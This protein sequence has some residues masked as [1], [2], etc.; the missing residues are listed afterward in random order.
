MTRPVPQPSE[1]IAVHHTDIVLQQHRHIR[2][3]HPTPAFLIFFLCRLQILTEL[4]RLHDLPDVLQ[5]L[6]NPPDLVPAHGQVRSFPHLF[7]NQ[8]VIFHQQVIKE[9]HPILHMLFPIHLFLDLPVI[10]LHPGSHLS[11]PYFSLFRLITAGR[12]YRQSFLL[13]HHCSLLFYSGVLLRVC[14]LPI[15]RFL[16]SLR[17]LLPF[18][19][20]RSKHQLPF[21][22]KVFMI[23][24]IDD[25]HSPVNMTDIRSDAHPPVSCLVLFPVIP[26]FRNQFNIGCAAAIFIPSGFPADQPRDLR[27]L[28]Q[29]HLPAPDLIP[30]QLIRRKSFPPFHRIRL[31]WNAVIP[32]IPIPFIYNG[33]PP[34]LLSSSHTSHTKNGPQIQSPFPE[35]GNKKA[36]R[37]FQSTSF[38]SFAI[39]LYHIFTLHKRRRIAQKNEVFS[40]NLVLYAIPHYLFIFL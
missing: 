31:F 4:E 7:F 28:C 30:F 34:S 33:H 40:E 26:A 13:L 17:T 10:L 39:L 11:F 21:T 22:V 12:F 38:S 19:N 14:F 32:V 20:Q 1:L 15:I 18:L 6:I 9:L 2:I 5:Q 29:D 27:N 24:L 37:P 25:H 3:S 36:C 23:F 8:A 35:P 16:F